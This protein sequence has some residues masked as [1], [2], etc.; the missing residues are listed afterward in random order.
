MDGKQDDGSLVNQRIRQHIGDIG[1][2][3]R[4]IY[5]SPS[6]EILQTFRDPRND[7]NYCVHYP[8]LSETSVSKHTSHIRR[9]DSEELHRWIRCGLGV[10]T[11]HA[12]TCQ[13]EVLQDSICPICFTSCFIDY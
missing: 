11:C 10:F 3:V 6:G 5:V 1:P 4:R 9:D 13:Q 2:K 12:T 8:T 7:L